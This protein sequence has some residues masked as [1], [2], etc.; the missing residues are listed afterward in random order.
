MTTS[1]TSS[2]RPPVGWRGSNSPGESSAGSTCLTT[3]A[4]VSTCR[5]R[6]MPSAAARVEERDRALVEDEQG[7]LLAA[8]RGRGGELRGERR[9]AGPRGA[10]DQ[11]AGALLDAAAEQ[12]IELARCRF[13]AW[14]ERLATRCS[15]ATRRGID[16]E[17]AV[18]D[19]VVV[20]PAAK[21]DAAV[22]D[23]AQ[24]AALG[25]VL[26][27]ELLEQDRRRARCSAPAGRDRRAV[28]SSSRS[29]RALAADEELLQRQ[30]LPPIA[31]RV[32]GQEPE[33]GQRIEHHARRAGDSRRRR[34]PA[35]SWRRAPP[36]TDGTSSV[37]HP[38]RAPPRRA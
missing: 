13:A 29:D 28:M 31:Q 14:R 22:L 15:A 24:P 19:D 30:D 36:R 2:L 7:R 34:S 5:R 16:L 21:R 8:R 35:A 37:L 27:V 1:L 38:D 18:A 32:S 3:T 23:D 33:L 9:F 25:A 26:G 17:A 11:R 10:D 6:S 12:R 4:P 20:I